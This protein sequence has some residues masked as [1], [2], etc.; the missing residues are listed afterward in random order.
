MSRVEPGE[1]ASQTDC[2]FITRSCFAAAGEA[3]S[4][5]GHQDGGKIDKLL[6]TCCW[7]PSAGDPRSW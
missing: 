7:G 3:T 1:Q 6:P 5:T 2:D 4:P